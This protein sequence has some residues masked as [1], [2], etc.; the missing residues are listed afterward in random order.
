MFVDRP[1]FLGF[2]VIELSK[3]LRYET[4]YDNF[5]PYLGEKNT[6]LPCMDT[7]SFVLSINTNHIIQESKNLHDLFDFSNLNSFHELFS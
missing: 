5:H 6:E 4:Y 3:L 2:A 7:D 1:I